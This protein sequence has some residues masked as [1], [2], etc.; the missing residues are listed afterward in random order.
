MFSELCP[1]AS[2]IHVLGEYLNTPESSSAIAA[3][4]ANHLADSTYGYPSLSKW[5]VWIEPIVAN[6]VDNDKWADAVRAALETWSRAIP[7]TQVSKPERAHIQVRHKQPLLRETKQGWRASN[8]RSLLQIAIAARSGESYLEPQVEVLVSPGLQTT[9]LQ[10]T[11]LH[12]LGHAFGLWGHSKIEEDI[13][14]FR[15]GATSF[16]RLSN[17][18]RR[19][20]RWL[21]S[22]CGNFG[23]P[24]AWLH[25]YDYQESLVL[26]PRRETRTDCTSRQLTS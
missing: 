26:F 11:A 17:R 24:L 21:R 25:S 9:V 15:Q 2:A 5:C 6:E 23:K 10:S 22:H 19:T 4:Y 14:H 13:M 8:G 16:L 18:D 1:P 7:L 12:E 20:L 3:D